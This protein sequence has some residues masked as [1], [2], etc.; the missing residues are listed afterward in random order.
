MA[1]RLSRDIVAGTVV[2]AF[3]VAVL[4]ALSRIPQARFQAIG[5]DLF[6]RLCAYGLLAGGAALVL[7]GLLRRAPAIA[8]PEWRAV[9]LIALAVVAFGVI[10]PRAGYALAGFA[11]VVIA[12]LAAR[13]TRLVPLLGFAAGLMA[14]SVVLFSFVLKVPMPIWPGF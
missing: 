2:A 10:A 7:R 6:P 4:A 12:G 14:F 3:A 13:E 5:P 11:T 9:A 8:L 1:A